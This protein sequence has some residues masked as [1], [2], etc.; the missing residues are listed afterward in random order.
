MILRGWACT[1]IATDNAVR[2]TEDSIMVSGIMNAKTKL[3]I[4][5]KK[6][7]KEHA[8][9]IVKNRQSGCL[10]CKVGGL[11]CRVFK[12][13]P[14]ASLFSPHPPQYLP[15]ASLLFIIPFPAG[16]EIENLFVN[17]DYCQQSG[18]LFQQ[19]TGPG[20]CIAASCLSII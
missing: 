14:N 2:N 7:C 10:T 6:K 5:L 9:I 18:G 8:S 15:C 19:V 12:D 17:D 13:P 11:V 16:L 4:F 20:S 3:E 1:P